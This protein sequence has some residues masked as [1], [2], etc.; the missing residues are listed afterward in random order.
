MTTKSQSKVLSRRQALSLLG[1]AGATAYAIPTVL[2]VSDANAWVRSRRVRTH[3]RFAFRERT[4]RFRTHRRFVFRE[5]TRRFRTDRG[6]AFRRTRRF[7]TRR[8]TWW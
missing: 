4:R 7:R 6:F 2:T 1:L 5:R 3:R 8:R